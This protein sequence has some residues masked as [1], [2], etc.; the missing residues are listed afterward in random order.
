[1]FLRRVLESEE[2]ASGTYDTGIVE[3]LIQSI[4]SEKAFRLEHENIFASQ[5]ESWIRSEHERVALL[6]TAFMLFEQEQRLQ[7]RVEKPGE[8]DGVSMNSWK[9][10]TAIRSNIRWS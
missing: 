10:M 8:H 4:N 7:A 1:M 9:Q 5:E 3:R 2:F 6:A